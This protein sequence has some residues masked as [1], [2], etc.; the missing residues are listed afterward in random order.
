MAL[1]IASARIEM[2]SLPGQS[3]HGERQT[4]WRRSEALA[5]GRGRRGF[6]RDNR[7][8]AGS[9]P[10]ASAAARWRSTESKPAR[11]EADVICW[12]QTVLRLEAM[13]ARAAASPAFPRKC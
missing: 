6:E 7:T 11:H 4:F 1:E 3:G 8:H 2:S 13:C 5:A 12:R 10:N 9:A